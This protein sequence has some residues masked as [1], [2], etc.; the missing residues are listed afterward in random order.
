MLGIVGDTGVS[1]GLPPELAAELCASA[2]RTHRTGVPDPEALAALRGSGLLGTAVPARYGGTGGGAPEVNEV[3]RRLAMVNPSLAIVAFQHFAV[4]A[5][6]AEWG[7]PRQRRELLPALADGSRL[8]ASAWSEPGAGAAKHHITSTGERR[9]DGRWTLTGAKSFTTA[10]SIADLYLVLVRTDDAA[11]GDPS[12][13]GS[14]GQSFFLVPGDCPGLSADLS[15]DLVGMRGSATGFVSLDGCVVADE[16]RLGPEGRAADIIAA[17]REYGATLG[18]VAAGIARAALDLALE[19]VVRRGTVA[20]LPV[21]HR[22][23]DTATRVEAVEAMIERSGA[24]SSPDPGL[25]TLHS[26]MFAST[27]AEQVC[28]E[29]AHLLGS[30]GYTTASDINRLVLDAR[31][32]ALMGPT[33]ELCRDIV[34]AGWAR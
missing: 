33:N 22:L 32:V 21:R 23:T 4:S 12:L 24:R 9:R 13:Y 6:I 10:A 34:A 1:P 3:V 25:T 7:S 26:K 8:A 19:H 20:A 30:A 29:L 5:R 2:A 15:L 31:A 18:A 28:L 17:V 11:H 27:T 16:D 14:P